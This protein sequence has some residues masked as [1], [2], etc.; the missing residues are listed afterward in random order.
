MK[1]KQ[2][3]WILSLVLIG[4]FFFLQ[5]G[6][7]KESSSSSTTSNSNGG[8]DVTDID[9]NV[10][11]SV[12]IGKQTWM[13]SNL[14][15]THYRNGVAI[16]NVS[17]STQWANDTTAAYCNS[18]NST[19]SANIYG[20]LYNWYAAASANN[21][22]PTG[23]HVAS[24]SEWTVLTTYLGNNSGGQLKITGTRYWNYPNTSATNSTGFSALGAGDR[25][26][27][28]V[29]HQLGIYGFWWTSSQS[30]GYGIDRIITNTSGGVYSIDYPK[31]IGFSVRCVKD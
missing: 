26:N 29:F 10:Y 21:L 25:S 15:T 14:K 17:D 12:V 19:D 20:R 13:S 4:L 6:C 27:V 18:Y 28:S 9:G 8:P 5:Y 31:N 2:N 11:H 30:G 1:R 22:A 24:D 3:L 23:W 16:P 7:K